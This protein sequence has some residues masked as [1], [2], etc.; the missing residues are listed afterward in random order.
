MQYDNIYIYI[1]YG[2]SSVDP[3]SEMIQLKP[4]LGGSGAATAR[5]P[6]EDRMLL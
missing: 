3:E 2:I 5:E 6:E 1:I 4:G